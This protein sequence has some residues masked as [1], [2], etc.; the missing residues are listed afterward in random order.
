MLELLIRFFFGGAVVS[1]FATLGDVVKPKSFA[2]LFSA[3][4]SVGR[5]LRQ[6]L[7]ERRGNSHWPVR[8]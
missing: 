8:R 6:L 1:A 5:R 3:A 4:P 7:R 2:G